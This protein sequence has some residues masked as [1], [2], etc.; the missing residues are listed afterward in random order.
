MASF[1]FGNLIFGAIGFVAFRYGRKM[2]LLKT[3]VIG[4][5]LML[6]TLFVY[7]T[8]YVYGIGV[9]LTIALFVFKD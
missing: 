4:V 3:S 2:G 6:Y 9:V 5:L 1:L 7:D 8:A